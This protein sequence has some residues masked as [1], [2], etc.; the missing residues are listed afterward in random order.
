MIVMGMLGGAPRAEARA[1]SSAQLLHS[2]PGPA[3]A[4]P[5]TSPGGSAGVGGGGGGTPSKQRRAGRRTRRQSIVAIKDSIVGLVVG[6]GG[7]ESSSTSA[8]K[9]GGGGG[10]GGPPPGPRGACPAPPHGGAK[11][12]AV[13]PDDESAVDLD[14]LL[15]LDDAALEGRLSDKIVTLLRRVTEE[16]LTPPPQ[17]DVRALS[18]TCVRQSS[19]ARASI[20]EW[21]RRR[22]FGSGGDSTVVRH[23][24]LLVLKLLLQQATR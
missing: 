3:P 6:G 16:S 14:A 15:A 21:L 2:N 22:L 8:G 10:G 4:P 13:I 24:A 5:P 11:T 17:E 12:S 23:K 9:A 20:I 19:E 1:R 7:S 18:E